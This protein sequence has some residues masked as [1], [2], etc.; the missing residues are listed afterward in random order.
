VL[1]GLPPGQRQAAGHP[2]LAELT[3]RRIRAVR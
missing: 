1:M 2:V 3:G